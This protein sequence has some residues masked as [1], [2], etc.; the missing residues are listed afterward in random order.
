MVYGLRRGEEWHRSNLAHRKELLSQRRPGRNLTCFTVEKGWKSGINIPAMFRPVWTRPWRPK[1][2]NMIIAGRH[3]ASMITGTE[4]V[5][6][7]GAEACKHSSPGMR[8]QP[9]A[10][11][12]TIPARDRL[13]VCASCSGS[14]PKVSL[15]LLMSILQGLTRLGGQRFKTWGQHGWQRYSH[16]SLEEVGVGEKITS[17]GIEP[18]DGH[19]L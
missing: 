17:R 13:T 18:S 10:H 7:S 2:C 5:S 14:R 16:T 6:M 12:A 19:E 8:R 15:S 11:G 4:T 1:P 3:S 9:R